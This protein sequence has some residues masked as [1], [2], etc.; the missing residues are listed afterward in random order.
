MSMNERATHEHASQSAAE[1]HAPAGR[2]VLA[3]A[4][5]DRCVQGAVLFS[6]GFSF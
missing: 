2:E 5:L 6:L 3:R 4:L 1:G